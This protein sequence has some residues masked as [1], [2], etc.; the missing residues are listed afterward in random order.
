MCNFFSLVTKGSGKMYYFNAEQR[1]AIANRQLKFTRYNC[2]IT[3]PDSHT[4][5]ATFYGL[6][7]D[8]CNKYEY[9]PFAGRLIR[10]QMNADRW[11]DEGVAK[12]LA[13]IDFRTIIPFL[14]SNFIGLN[15]IRTIPHVKKNGSMFASD[16]KLAKRIARG[17]M[18]HYREIVNM[19][20]SL[21]SGKSI[22]HMALGNNILDRWFLSS[23]SGSNLD[24]R[25]K[26]DFNES[27]A[28]RNI[29]SDDETLSMWGVMKTM[30]I[31]GCIQKKAFK[32]S[33]GSPSVLSP[34]IALCRDFVRLLNRGIIVL[35]DRNRYG[36]F[37]VGSATP[38]E[39]FKF[40]A[41]TEETR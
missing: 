33:K 3:M 8:K 37:P 19:G 25:F 7:E 24:C 39:I 4:S 11:D 21:A 34:V 30:H 17:I 36:A 32:N 5:I 14:N 38:L 26:N 13:A 35:G 41:Q 31:F 6:D 1:I 29:D 9:D 18:R 12:K 15:K 28:V 2:F 22:T 27:L 23:A 20:L 16:K 40:R 10:D